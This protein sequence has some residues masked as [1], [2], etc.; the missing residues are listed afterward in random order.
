MLVFIL[1]LSGL[2]NDWPYFDGGTVIQT[3]VA[4]SDFHGFFKTVRSNEPVTSNRF[5]GFRER[6]VGYGISAHHN[7][8]FLRESMSVFDFSFIA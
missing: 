7:F 2:R 8:A 1:K 5:L 3:G 4:F 6:A